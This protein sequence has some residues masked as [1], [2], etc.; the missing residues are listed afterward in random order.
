MQ[1]TR[2]IALD[3]GAA[4][5]GV[6]TADSGVKIASPLPAIGVD[7]KEVSEIQRLASEQGAQVLVV[8]YPRNMSGEATAQ[9]DVAVAF[10]SRLRAVGLRVEFQDESLTSVAAEAHLRARGKTYSKGDIDSY[11]ACVI[12]TD[13]LESH[14]A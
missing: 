7:G 4:R 2:Y 9:T 3:V 14:H 10:A 12:L 1:P 11:A 8:G 6:A 5:I 13:Y